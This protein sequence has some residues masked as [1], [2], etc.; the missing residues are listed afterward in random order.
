MK[1]VNANFH[2]ARWVGVLLCLAGS[3]SVNAVTVPFG[4]N[5][6]SGTSGYDVYIINDVATNQASGQLNAYYAYNNGNAYYETGTGTFNTAPPASVS[7]L[8]TGAFCYSDKSSY[9]GNYL[10]YSIGSADYAFNMQFWGDGGKGGGYYVNLNP[11]TGGWTTS[12]NCPGTGTSLIPSISTVNS[13]TAQTI[14]NQD[15]IV[16]IA[17]ASTGGSDNGVSM[18]VTVNPAGAASGSQQSSGSTTSASSAVASS[19]KQ[20]TGVSAD[21]SVA[22]TEPRFGL[23]SR[24]VEGRRWSVVQDPKSQ[25][26]SGLIYAANGL[27]PDRFVSC[28]FVSD[29]GNANPFLRQST[30]KCRVAEPCTKGHCG[31]GTWQAMAPETIV[32]PGSVFNRPPLNRVPLTPPVTTPPQGG[33]GDIRAALKALSAATDRNV[34]I[35]PDRKTTLINTVVLKQ[36]WAMVYT[37]K[38]LFT[39]VPHGALGQPRFVDCRQTSSTKKDISFAC[40]EAYRCNFAPCED[41]QWSAV[42]T[43]TL[44]KSFFQPPKGH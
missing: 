2:P 17:T 4:A 30:F 42:E 22:A 5:C 33:D 25:N 13:T 32:L 44:P 21:A 40:A 36:R 35:S 26:V 41:N 3:G 9:T 43:M 16:T 28:K 12:G 27:D 6:Y 10:A 20:E 11:I 31:K 1:R 18:N 29:D 23:A 7:T 24:F 14:C 38:R 15:Y 19:A 8:N 34:Q 37:K 39:A